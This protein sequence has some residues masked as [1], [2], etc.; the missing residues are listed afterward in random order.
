[1]LTLAWQ[2]LLRLDRAEQVGK[3]ARLHDRDSLG[4][5]VHGLDREDDLVHH[6]VG[7]VVAPHVAHL[8]RAQ[9]RQQF[10]HRDLVC[11]G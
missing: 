11:H 7:D 6:E 5:R 9:L 3:V 10:V 8:G 2:R 4:E 1:M